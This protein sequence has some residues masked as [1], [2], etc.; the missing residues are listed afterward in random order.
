MNATTTQTATT[1]PATLSAPCGQCGF[2]NDLGSTVCVECR[3]DP[4]E[5][6]ARCEDC[7]GRGSQDI[8]APCDWMTVTVDCSD[9]GGEG[10][11]FVGGERLEAVALLGAVFG[12]LAGE[13]VEQG[14]AA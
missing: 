4:R 8:G 1:H 5:V 6:W 13:I 3:Q 7:G 12:S 2:P 11:T 10:W 14:G 9:C